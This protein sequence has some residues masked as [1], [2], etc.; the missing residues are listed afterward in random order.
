MSR[1]VTLLG[2]PVTLV[3]ALTH[4]PDYDKAFQELTKML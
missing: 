4:H 3:G 2:N 1:T